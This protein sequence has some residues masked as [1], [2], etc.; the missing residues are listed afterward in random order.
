MC[1]RIHECVRARVRACVYVRTQ[2][3]PACVH[4]WIVHA[5]THTC[6]REPAKSAS[7]SACVHVR[8]DVWVDVGLRGA[9]AFALFSSVFVRTESDPTKSNFPARKNRMCRAQIDRHRRCNLVKPL[10]IPKASW[11]CQH[12]SRTVIDPCSLV[13]LST[14]AITI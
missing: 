11:L 8:G 4:T 6:V 9:G 12:F 2:N 3:V 10:S 14:Q 5:C 13:D 1:A 7:K